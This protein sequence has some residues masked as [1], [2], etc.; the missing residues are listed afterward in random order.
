VLA[1]YGTLAHFSFHGAHV[2]NGVTEH[3]HHHLL[4]TS[5]AL[6]TASSVPPHF[7]AEVVSTTTYL[8]NTQPSWALQ[9][10]IPFEHLCGKMPNYSSIHLFGYVC[11]VLLA[12]R[13]RANLIAQSIECVF[14]GYSAEHKG[15]RCWDPAT[16][17]KR[18]SRDVFF[19]ESCPFYQCSTTNASPASLVDTLSFLLFPNAPPT[20]LPIPCSILQSS[21]SSSESPPVVPD[22]TVKPPVTQFY[23]HRGARLS[24]TLAS[25]DELPSDVLSSSFIEDVSS[26]PPVEPSSLVD[27]S[28]EQFA[29]RS[30]HLHR[31]PDCYSPSAF[32]AITLTEPT[33][34]HDA[35]LHQEWQHAMAKEIATLERT[36][37]WDLVPCPPR[38]RLITCKWVY[39]IKAR[40]DGSLERYN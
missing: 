38:V 15:C 18:M 25:S 17:R 39:K 8:I 35:I 33:S 32:T 27:S 4:E 6:I 24:D 10:G 22:Y 14:L 23:S 19:D 40:S 16:H 7:W 29:R 20:S 26:S 28:S 37:M 31:P 30:H 36:G 1:E 21:V 13:E 3:K 12:P 2:Q 5:R 34:Y 9:G 11:Y